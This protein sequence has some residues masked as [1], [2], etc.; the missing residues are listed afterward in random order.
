MAVLWDNRIT[1]HIS[2]H[3]GALIRLNLI[4]LT[5][6]AIVDSSMRVY[7]KTAWCLDHNLSS[8]HHSSFD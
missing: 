3:G 4:N 5:K 7:G 1:A 2:F 6:S 8:A